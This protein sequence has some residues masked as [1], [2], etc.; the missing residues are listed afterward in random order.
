MN[1]EL[2]VQDNN[3]GIVF[4]I[5]ELVT[6]ASW[7]TSVA[8]Q[9]GKLS[10]TCINDNKAIMNEGSIVSFKVNG[11]GV[12]FGYIF[13]RE[14]SDKG[15][16]A[17]TAYDQLRYLKNKDTYVISGMTASQVFT[18]ICNDFKL[19]GQV[20]D[21]SPYVV[22]PRVHDN[23]SLFEIIQYGIDQTL[24]NTGN[25]YILKDN[26][27]IMQFMNV[28]TLKTDLFIGDQSALTAFDY[29]SSI[30]DDT[31]NQVKIVK[32]NK[33]TKKRELYIVKDS[34]TIK[35]WGMLQYFEKVDEKANA[36]QI[37]TR[38]E[39]ILKLKNRATKKLKLDCIGDLKVSA[40]SG[41]VLGIS[42]LENEGLGTNQYFMVT[43]CTHSFLNRHHTMQLELQVSI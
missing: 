26:F 28:N 6:S 40:G 43:A 17:V 42:A 37:Q 24:I 11:N 21:T 33:E 39:S 31:Y 18:K 23:K 36:A 41:I 12:F 7:E 8:D 4:D 10:F 2:I 35:K 5:S 34:A 29:S 20:I 16:T 13:K 9:P 3:S 22:A 32:E 14:Q 38:A 25:W 19:Q 30:D 27:G 1:I 15:T